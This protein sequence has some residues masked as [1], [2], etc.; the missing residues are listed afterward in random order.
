MGRRALAKVGFSGAAVWLEGSILGIFDESG[1]DGWVWM[2][3][4]WIWV[5]WRWIVV[6]FRL[7]IWILFDGR[8]VLL[9]SPELLPS[10]IYL[11]PDDA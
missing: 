8:Q 7:V 3:L 5:E 11:L 10:F 2:E 9:H 6:Q 1:E 4:R